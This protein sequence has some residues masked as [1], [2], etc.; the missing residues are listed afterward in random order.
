MSAS[1]VPRFQPCADLA[2]LLTC[3]AL[4]SST[5]SPLLK[6]TAKQSSSLPEPK[7]LKAAAAIVVA[8]WDDESSAEIIEACFAKFGH[9]TV[10]SDSRLAQFAWFLKE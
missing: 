8:G 10:R 3:Y 7:H 6:F 1:Y 5:V 9:D 4:R 2:A